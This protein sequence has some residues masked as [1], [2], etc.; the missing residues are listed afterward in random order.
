M[1]LAEKRAYL[2]GR[3]STS[4]HD[5]YLCATGGLAVQVG[6]PIEKVCAQIGIASGQRCTQRRA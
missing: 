6:G 2:G 1:L 5:G 4:D 3:F